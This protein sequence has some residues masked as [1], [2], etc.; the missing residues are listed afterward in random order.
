M[1]LEDS[2]GGSGLRQYYLSK[3]EE[4]QVRLVLSFSNESTLWFGSFIRILWVDSHIWAMWGLF[5]FAFVL[6]LINAPTV[7]VQSNW[8]GVRSITSDLLFSLDV[9]KSRLELLSYSGSCKWSDS[10]KRHD[11]SHYHYH[12][13]CLNSGFS[14]SFKIKWCPLHKNPFKL[15][16][17]HLLLFQRHKIAA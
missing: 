4:L 16:Q 3:I 7:V 14:R 12:C 5:V 10:L 9:W 6:N 17:V 13:A 15:I 2:K 1:E 11:N 8:K